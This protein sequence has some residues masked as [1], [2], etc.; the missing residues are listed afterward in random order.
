[1]IGKREPEE[2]KVFPNIKPEPNIVNSRNESQP[3][4]PVEKEPIRNDPMEID[5]ATRP[6]VPFDNLSAPLT[7]SDKWKLLPSFFQIKGIAR[8]HIDSFNYLIDTEIKNIVRANEKLVSDLDPRWYM[9]YT[10]VRV[11]TPQYND[12]NCTSVSLTPHMCRLRDITY[13]AEI[14]VDV[15]YTR[16]DELVAAS[17]IGIGKIPIMLRSKNCVLSKKSDKELAKLGEC[18]LDPGGYFVVKGAEKVILMQEQLSKNRIIIEKDSRGL[19]ANV[20]SSTHERKSRTT[21]IVKKDRLYLNHNTLDPD[22]NMAIVMRAMGVETDQEIIQLVGTDP[23]YVD[24]MAPTLYECAQE[25]VFTTTQALLYMGK[26]TK[27]YRGPSNTGAF[28]STARP[29]PKKVTSAT[30][31]RD[32]LSG[33]TLH[34][35]QR[36]IDHARDL[37][38]GVILAHVP[39]KQFNF[40][41]KIIYFAQM[42]RRLLVA[43]DDPAAIDD[44]DYYGNKRL[45][46]AGQL[47]SLLFEDLF[48]KFNTD[49]KKQVDNLIGKTQS[50]AL[51]E[52]S[53]RRMSDGMD[54]GR[55]TPRAYID[56]PK[57]FRPDT[58]TNGL[59]FAI[60]TGNWNVKRFK[61]ERSGVTEVLSRLSFISVVGM[62]TRITSQFEKTRKVSGPR[63]L[64]PSQWGMLCP[65]DTPEG[66]QCGLVKNLALMTHV[67]TDDE[68]A[69]LERLLFDLGV[70]PTGSL[71][72][73]EINDNDIV[74]LNG[75][76]LGIHLQ[77][78]ALTAKLRH[79]RRT[80]MIGEFVSI[81]E[82]PQQKVVQ[83]ACDGGRVT[84]PLIIVDH[85]GEPMIS[86]KH[87][88]MIAKGLMVW[89]DLLEQGLI[90]YL[91][92]NEENNTLIATYETDIIR[93]K[94]THLE[95]A[96]WTILGICA[97]I[98]PY[99]HHNQSPRNTYQCAMGKQAIGA[100]AYNQHMRTD[101]LLYTLAYPQRPLVQTRTLTLV[102]FERLPGGQNASLMV[103]SYSGYD[104]EDAVILNKASIDRGFG[105][106]VVL[107][108]HATGCKRY[109]NNASDRIMPAPPKPIGESKRDQQLVSRWSSR[110]QAL[111][112]DGIV[113]PGDKLIAGNVIANKQ[114]PTATTTGG[115][116]ID[117]AL[118]QEPYRAQPMVFKGTSTVVA[119]RVLITSNDYEHV[120]VKCMLRE[121]RRPELG[122]KFSSRHGQKGVCGL[123]VNQED[124]PFTDNGIVPDLIMN[125]H[126]FPSRM[127]VGKL[128]E[129]VAG[130]AGVF[131][132]KFRYGT[133][134]DGDRLEDCAASLVAAGYNYDG[135]D[136]AYSGTSGEPLR[137]Y[138]FCGPI[139][140]QK[141]KHMVKDKMHARARGPRALLTRQ[142]TEGRSRDGGLRL[143]EMERDCLIGYGASMLLM[144]RLMVSSDQFTVHACHECGM[145]GYKEWCQT[146]ESGENVA[147]L[148]IP[149][150]CKLL[151]QELQAMNVVP[152]LKLT[153]V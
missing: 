126:G 143:G 35:N 140:Y 86:S 42:M 34:P 53:R 2:R 41:D 89:R 55:G 1:M 81:F 128:I 152:K 48:K 151:F 54:L 30:R 132:G 88:D 57:L 44:K 127:T 92:V 106:C 134:F 50:K 112:A 118:T 87:V 51:K 63:A 67:T 85:R 11:M 109:A 7:K 20:Q 19:M 37:L 25:G 91:D 125:P 146:C 70:Q 82:Q 32:P 133:A 119:E 97:G 113:A 10:E 65:A 27:T 17:R 45:E 76:I 142:P 80:G 5:S 120:L 121:T 138:V 153:P 95:I 100:I 101:T 22:I 18:P 116:G 46:L 24:L 144:E 110:Y 148:K 84:R 21:V 8:Q 79:L 78:R 15:Q 111:D 107:R 68:P 39:V 16:G 26:K 139:F 4:Q 77:P 149:Y 38:A 52:R 131:E 98:I 117:P 60:S 129:F 28:R 122:D 124:M 94:T 29:T 64:Q 141:L 108:K 75:L 61:M 93:G 58:I 59:E 56:V 43:M 31:A 137:A 102:G 136:F 114:V 90:E 71:S 33:L 147:S 123:I 6:P 12:M 47:L 73:E 40:W 62:M 13:S 145:I 9:K 72:G 115:A 83:V 96:P 99:P 74:F 104:I 23:R 105:R 150:A 135:K 66:E 36:K 14:Q 130:K 3:R 103:M 69:A 49:L